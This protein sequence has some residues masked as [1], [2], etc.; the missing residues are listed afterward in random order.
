M[1]LF[2]QVFRRHF[3]GFQVDQLVEPVYNSPRHNF[4][5]AKIAEV[6]FFLRLDSSAL[7]SSQV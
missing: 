1:L 7:T 3:G 5:A 4:H 6:Y 2:V